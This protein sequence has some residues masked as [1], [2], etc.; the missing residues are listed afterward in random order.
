MFLKNRFYQEQQILLHEIEGGWTSASTRSFDPKKISPCLGNATE[1]VAMTEDILL[2]L[3]FYGC[4]SENFTVQ[5]S[6]LSIS[7]QTLYITAYK[8]RS[9]AKLKVRQ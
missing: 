2:P 1:A 3:I 5:P 8:Y 9:L 4:L 6:K 7:W